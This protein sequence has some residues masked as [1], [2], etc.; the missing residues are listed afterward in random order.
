MQ[1]R[2]RRKFRRVKK[3]MLLA[4]MVNLIVKGDLLKLT[5]KKAR[6]RQTRREGTNEEEGILED[7]VDTGTLQS[8]EE[9]AIKEKEED[10]SDVEV[11][12]P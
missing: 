4:M 6:K 9:K 3:M 12:F 5:M 11:I 1:L 2:K 10:E 7:A 8:Q